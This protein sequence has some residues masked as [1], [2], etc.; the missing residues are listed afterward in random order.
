MRRA[1]VERLRAFVDAWIVDVGANIG[2][3]TVVFARWLQTGKVLAIEP[4]PENFRRLTAIVAAR[5]LGDRVDA[6][7]IA[8]AERSGPGHLVLSAESHA[9]RSA[10]DLM[11]GADELVINIGHDVGGQRESNALISPRLGEDRRV[12]ADDFGAHV[13][14]RPGARGIDWSLRR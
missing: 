14:Q 7:Q 1:R 11:V 13:H 12:D 10:N 8:A 6:R 5:G 2:F 9:D 4:E 3:F